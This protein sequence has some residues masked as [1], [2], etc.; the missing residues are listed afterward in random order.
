MRKYYVSVK[1]QDTPYRSYFFLT[2]IP[3]LRKGDQ[4][5][6][7]TVNGIS[8]AEVDGYITVIPQEIVGK[9]KW[10][11]QKV[12]LSDHEAR[13]KVAAQKREIA[14][15]MEKRVR[16]MDRAS[17]FAALAQH[18]GVMLNLFREYKALDQR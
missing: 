7:H 16:Q 4:V 18:D 8:L 3:D 11:I 9:M 14:E 10:V 1:F 12:D 13:E 17:L 5:V 6:V 15:K 2:S